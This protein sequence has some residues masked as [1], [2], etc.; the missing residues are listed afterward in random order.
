MKSHR[1]AEFVRNMT[2][3]AE[4]PAASPEVTARQTGGRGKAQDRQPPAAATTRAGLKHIGGYFDAETVE[5][6]AL[7]RARLSLDNSQLIKLAIDELYA[8]HRAKRAFGDA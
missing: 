1:S 8:K 3:E 6:V 4:P 2:A 5:K 7:L